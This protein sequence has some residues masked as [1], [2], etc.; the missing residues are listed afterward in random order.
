MYITNIKITSFDLLKSEVSILNLLCWK[1]MAH[2]IWPMTKYSLKKAIIFFVSSLQR[3]ICVASR[4]DNNSD[5]VLSVIE[6]FCFSLVIRISAVELIK[7][8]NFL[9]T[10]GLSIKI[11]KHVITIKT[12]LKLVF[13]TNFKYY[14]FYNNYEVRYVQSILMEVDKR[15]NLGISNIIDCVIQFQ[16]LLLIDPMVENT[17]PEHFYGFRRGRTIHQALS[18][19]SR[20]IMLSGTKDFFIVIAE[21]EKYLDSISYKYIVTHFPFP[22]KY[23]TFFYRWIKNIYSFGVVYGLDSYGSCIL[24]PII[25]N[26]VLAKI[27]SH[28]FNDFSSYTISIKQKIVYS[29]NMAVS[30]RYLICYANNIILKVQNKEE[31]TKALLKL[32]ILLE[33]VSLRL[34]KKRSNF[35]NLSTK[36]KFH[37]LGFTFLFLFN[38]TIK[39]S[40]LLPYFTQNIS[41]KYPL[42][43]YVYITYANYFDIKYQ[44]KR[45]IKGLHHKYFLPILLEVSIFIRGISNY[46]NITTNK[47]FILYLNYFIDKCFWRFLVSK[48]RYNG[49]YRTSW[50]YKN[51]FNKSTLSSSSKL[52]HRALK[53]LFLI[54]K[55][56]SDVSFVFVNQL[57]YTQP[58]YKFILPLL[59]R[60]KPYYLAFFEYTKEKTHIYNIRLNYN[61][62]DLNNILFK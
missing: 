34:D 57:T 24:G 40:K 46:Y 28:F 7:N 39:Y 54:L 32:Q 36:A 21:I 8:K 22:I 16:F 10:F 61:Q 38:R 5:S 29:L 3:Y 60:K 27:F 41:S 14:N 53:S 11:I 58:L 30:T 48:Y 20:N 26:F 51:F 18:F 35:Y 6:Y 31:A 25:F 17:L 62:Y 19:L 9:L 45:K 4:M 42:I 50:V 43:V 59:I 47:Y 15:R 44:L 56:K 52:V 12:C 49:L 37:W 55:K 2:K 33:T 13:Q 1:Y 23:R